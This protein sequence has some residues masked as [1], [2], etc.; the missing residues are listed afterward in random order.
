MGAKA[1]RTGDAAGLPDLARLSLELA[2]QR[3][4]TAR[5]RAAERG[6]YVAA[7]R[8]HRRALALG[9]ALAEGDRAS[10]SRQFPGTYRA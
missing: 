4:W 7:E 8:W 1:T 5:A 10:R 9:A 6:D 3:A 2:W